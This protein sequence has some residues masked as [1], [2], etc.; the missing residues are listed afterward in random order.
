MHLTYD[1]NLCNGMDNLLKMMK[2]SI[3]KDDEKFVKKI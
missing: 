1:A 3:K 2:K